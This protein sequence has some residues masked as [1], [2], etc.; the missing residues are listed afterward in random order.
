[1]N[2]QELLGISIFC[3]KT[4]FHLLEAPNIEVELLALVLRFVYKRTVLTVA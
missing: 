3:N 4:S 2:G 1:M